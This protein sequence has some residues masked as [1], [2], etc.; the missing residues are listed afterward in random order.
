MNTKKLFIIL[1]AL[2]AAAIVVTGLYF[3]FFAPNPQ[4]TTTPNTLSVQTKAQQPVKVKDFTK[5]YQA[6]TPGN[7]LLVDN[8]QYSISY[9]TSD[10][11][12]LITLESKP[13]KTARAAAEQDI[14]NRLNIT[15]AQACQLKVSVKV[16]LNVDP[17]YAGNELGLSFCPGSVP[18]P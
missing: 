12:F 9:S 17:N 8:G 15:Q 18:L 6:A 3:A 11:S 16:P 10:Q 7:G 2:V 5:N 13:L 4:Q 14:L 1:A